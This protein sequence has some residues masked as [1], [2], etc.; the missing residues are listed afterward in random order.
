[1]S[2]SRSASPPEAEQ[3]ARDGGLDPC[4]GLTEAQAR[5]VRHEGDLLVL[6]CPGSGK[7]RML[8]ARAIACLQRPGRR[9]VL[10]TFTRAAAQEMKERI[11]AQLSGTDVR[12]RLAVGTFDA[13][14]VRQARRHLNLGRLPTAME[15]RQLIERVTERVHGPVGSGVSRK[16]VA[17][18]IG[19]ENRRLTPGREEGMAAD[20]WRIYSEL[21]HGDGLVDLAAMA[22]AV[23]HGM[24]A[25]EVAPYRAQD[26]LVDEFQDAD[27]LQLAWLRR[28]ALAGSTIT[29][30]ADDDQSIYGFRSAL[31]AGGLRVLQEELDAERVDLTR[32]YRCGSSIVDAA[33]R[34]I[35]HNHERFDKAIHSWAGLEGSVETRLAPSWQEEQERIRLELAGWIHQG[36]RPDGTLPSAALLARTNALLDE[37][38]LAVVAGGL[39][40]IR[41]AGGSIWQGEG[42]GVVYS[43]L[44]A[45]EGDT[46]AVQRALQVLGR[47]AGI[48]NQELQRAGTAAAVGGLSGSLS[49]DLSTG[50]E[51]LVRALHRAQSHLAAGRRAEAIASLDGWLADLEE[52]VESERQART[53][54][55]ARRCLE[56]VGD[57]QGALLGRLRRLIAQAQAGGSSETDDELSGGPAV[58]LAT[59]HGAKGLEF[60]RVWIAGVDE[61]RLPH[62]DG[63]SVEEER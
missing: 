14:I 10:C 59:L 4:A 8:V 15:S 47:L 53:L 31:G 38:E 49:C 62:R 27:E 54:G 33:A 35:Q 34:L 45:I 50:S 29:V 32:C 39:R 57:G 3:A 63:Y 7:T 22:R 37:L 26:V 52:Q 21:L 58:V 60:D 6:A 19:Q 46:L 25:G 20:Y 30:V 42:A 44:E 2:E 5:A 61:Q 17:Q 9:V 55:I 28:H 48:G 36:C 23:I 41:S 56:I 1:M 43:L 13:L 51:R 40:A 11:R 12:Q 16:D 24:E 18:A